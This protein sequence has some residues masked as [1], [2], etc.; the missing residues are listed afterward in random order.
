MINEDKILSSGLTLPQIINHLYR[1]ANQV[2]W[3]RFEIEWQLFAD[4]VEEDLG[5]EGKARLLAETEA[6]VTDKNIG[7]TREGTRVKSDAKTIMNY[8]RTC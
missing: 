5:P 6:L 4:W 8:Y 3:D 1:L 7:P 2:S